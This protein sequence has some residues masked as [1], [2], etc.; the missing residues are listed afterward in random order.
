MT[1]DYPYK[2]LDEIL[3]LFKQDDME[4]LKHIKEFD[5]PKLLLD[6][7]IIIDV[8]F[9]IQILDKLVEEKY[10]HRGELFITSK[11]NA[12]ITEYDRMYNL[13]FEGVL[14]INGDGYLVKNK[15]AEYALFWDKVAFWLV[16]VGTVFAGIYGLIEIADSTMVAYDHYLHIM[17]HP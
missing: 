11:P 6:K 15:K 10:L 16:T 4:F 1:N 8:F 14:L 2:V 9:M 3:K 7:G 5:I 17:Q 13:T 12:E